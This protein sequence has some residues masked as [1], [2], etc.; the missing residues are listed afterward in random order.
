[1]LLLVH[2]VA[3]LKVQCKQRYRLLNIRK[4]NASKNDWIGTIAGF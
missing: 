4:F 2:E 3:A 1:M